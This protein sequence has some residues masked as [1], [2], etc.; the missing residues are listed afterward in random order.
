MLNKSVRSLQNHSELGG[1]DAQKKA[2]LYSHSFIPLRYIY[3]ATNT[4]NSRGLG[5]IY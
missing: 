1:D 5:R 3:C 4:A 2:Y